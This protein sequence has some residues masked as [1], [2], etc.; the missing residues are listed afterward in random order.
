[1]VIIGR[2]RARPPVLF[3]NLFAQRRWHPPLHIAEACWREWHRNA[4]G[5]QHHL[6]WRKLL[7]AV[8]KTAQWL[9]TRWRPQV[10]SSADL[11][12]EIVSDNASRHGKRGRVRKH[13]GRIGLNGI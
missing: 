1:M 7:Y 4:R 11:A 3:S 5:V 2:P 12:S 13:M 9:S 8:P 10:P 6:F